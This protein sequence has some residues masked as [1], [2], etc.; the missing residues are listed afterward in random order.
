[1]IDCKAMNKK[2]DSLINEILITRWSD[3]KPVS[4]A[5][6][7]SYV[8]PTATAKRFSQNENLSIYLLI[9]V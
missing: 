7:Y 1:M 6:N 8:Y 5:T 3:N 9:K 2:G 4:A